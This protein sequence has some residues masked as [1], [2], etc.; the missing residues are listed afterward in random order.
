SKALSSGIPSLSSLLGREQDFRATFKY[1]E[2]FRHLATYPHHYHDEQGNIKPS[3]LF[4]DPV[5]DIKVVLQ[6]VSAFL[7]KGSQKDRSTE[8]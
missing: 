1:K 3:P 8:C 5:E 4:G 6:E 7:S 2:E